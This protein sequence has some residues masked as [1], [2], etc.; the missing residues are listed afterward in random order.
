MVS[1]F[2]LVPAVNM[3]NNLIG[4]HI[5]WSKNE[6][7]WMK[8]K[9]VLPGKDSNIVNYVDRKLIKNLNI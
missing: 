9:L 7:K 1:T 2:V 8:Q 6:K 4:T 5:H 3:Q